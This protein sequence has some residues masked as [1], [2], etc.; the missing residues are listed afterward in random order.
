MSD[1]LNGHDG[2]RS[3]LLNAINE[4]AQGLAN[5]KVNAA[6][7]SAMVKNSNVNQAVARDLVS[8]ADVSRDGRD[9]KLREF[10]EKLMAEAKANRLKDKQFEH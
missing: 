6:E 2:D 4:V 9:D 5:K 3:A 1:A 8:N 10:E 7:H